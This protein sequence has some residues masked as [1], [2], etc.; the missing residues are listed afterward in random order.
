MQNL[1]E[2]IIES[3]SHLTAAAKAMN[4]RVALEKIEQLD[5]DVVV[6]DLEMPEM[7][8]IEFLKKRKERGITTPVVILSSHAR[9]GAKIT[10]EAV[11][12]GA[13]DFIMKPS[14]DFSRNIEEVGKKLI[15]LLKAYGSKY[16]VKQHGK[17]KVPNAEDLILLP[18]TP[19]LV[20]KG[21]QKTRKFSTNKIMVVAIGVS[22]GG[23]NAL[24]EIFSHI[25]PSLSAPIVV[26]QH[27]PPGFTKEFAISLN[28]VCPLQV[29]EAEDK[30]ILQPGRILIAPG[31]RHMEL[32][33]RQLAVVCRISAKP[34]RNGHR[35]SAD[36]LFRSVAEVFGG[37]SLGIIMTGMG[38]DGA[39]EIGTLFHAGGITLAQDEESSVVYGMPR[40]AVESGYINQVVALEDLAGTINHIVTRGN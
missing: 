26:V 8:G 4:G 2:K 11:S 37:N 6:L 19:P 31:G 13:S 25:D 36:V 28:Q 27:M 20:P 17:L 15:P 29:K 3:D 10:M 39:A 33:R 32:E 34:P 38:S 23:P 16:R 7:N 14:G 35:P 18:D 22:T 21:P 24:R 40:V 9:R 1:I 5:P 12:L 30:D